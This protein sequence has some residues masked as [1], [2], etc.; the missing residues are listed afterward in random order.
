MNSSVFLIILGK[1][2]ITKSK[3]LDLLSFDVPV[4]TGSKVCARCCSFLTVILNGKKD[5]NE[6]RY[7]S[8]DDSSSE[9]LLTVCSEIESLDLATTQA[10]TIRMLLKYYTVAY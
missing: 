2:T 3:A 10:C 7:L 6:I 9:T 8:N 5:Y 4:V 1:V